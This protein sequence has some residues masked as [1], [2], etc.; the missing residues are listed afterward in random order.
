MARRSDAAALSL[1]VQVARRR[2]PGL[3]QRRETRQRRRA[4][5]SQG[6]RRRARSQPCGGGIAAGIARG[7]RGA[8]PFHHALRGTARRRVR[9]RHATRNPAD[10]AHRVRPPPQSF[11]AL[12][13][14]APDRRRF[15]RH[16][17]RHPRYF[18]AAFL[19]AVFDHPGCARIRP[20]GA[21]AVR[22]V[23]LAFRRRHFRRHR[24]LYRLHGGDHGMAHGH[25]AACE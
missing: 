20:G 1:G 11:V 16:R 22:Q 13:P 17:A 19:H 8:A 21:R 24:A 2:C 15:T 7:I 9:A 6:S 25:T 3:S 23:R 10:R 18:D 12:S 14:G 5:G 4:A